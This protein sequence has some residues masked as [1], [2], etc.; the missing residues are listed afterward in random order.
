MFKRGRSDNCL[1]SLK[2]GGRF[3]VPQ[4]NQGHPH[5]IV[6][7]QLITTRKCNFACHHC[8]FSCNTRGAH[9]SNHVFYKA[10][11]YVG[12][13]G[14]NFIGGEPTLHPLFRKHFSSIVSSSPMVR[15][16]TNGSWGRDEGHVIAAIA[17]A[18]I[19]T[20][21]SSVFVR[22]S[23]DRWHRRFISEE[24][25]HLAADLLSKHGVE[26]SCESMDDSVVFPLGRASTGPVRLFLDQD[27]QMCSPAECVKGE[28]DPWDSISID[29][30]GSV[31][32][33]SHHQA[34]IGN[35]L[36]DSMQAIE[37]KAIEFIAKVSSQNPLV[38]DCP[39]CAALA[40]KG[41]EKRRN[42][43]TLDV[44]HKHRNSPPSDYTKAYI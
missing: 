25:L 40:L 36:T 22:I 33:C 18:V 6:M 39:Q 7:I 19:T 26:C 29:I 30:D 23:N 32:A 20:R 34:V 44:R 21:S 12:I 15:L 31:S 16:V 11:E 4:S 13:S 1:P 8:M 41:G 38:R 43:T 35:I 14:A 37:A 3:T 2:K 5:M 42:G 27:S 28:Y 24:D 10:M 9:M 17:D